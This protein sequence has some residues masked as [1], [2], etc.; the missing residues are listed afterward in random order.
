MKT[1]P[2]YNQLKNRQTKII[3]TNSITPILY[4]TTGATGVSVS[5]LPTGV[6]YAWSNNTLTISGTP[7]SV[8]FSKYILNSTGGCP[9]SSDPGSLIL[10]H[11][12]CAYTNMAGSYKVIKDDWGD[13]NANDVVTF[14]YDGVT[15]YWNVGLGYGITQSITATG[16]AGGTA[17]AIPY[18]TGA[19]A[20]AFT[21]PG[22][23]GQIL[24]SAGAGSPTWVTPSYVDITT[25]QTIG[26]SKTFTGTSTFSGPVT[27]G[28]TNLPT[29]TGAT[30]QVLTL[31]AAGTAIWQNTGGSFVSMNATGSSSASAKYIVF[32]GATASQTITIPSA[33]TVGAG[34]EITIKNVASVPVNIAATAGYLIQD[35]STLTSNTAS[36]GIEPSNNWLRLVSDGTN[37]YLFRALF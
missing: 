36:L 4:K 26:G 17:G 27:I 9:I 5:G 33:V 7:T 19:G 34:W 25:T 11:R 6:N 29:A 37:W 35:N 28:G 14:Y 23:T 24:T 13:W 15:C 1:T 20:T 18:Q 10:A 16:L 8:G 12:N 2:I 3:L 22:T 30:G 32:T 31:S 21:S